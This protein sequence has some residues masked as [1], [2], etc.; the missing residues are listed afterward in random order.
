MICLLWYKA[1]GPHHLNNDLIYKAYRNHSLG[2]AQLEKDR[3]VL[4]LK[5]VIDQD[6][7]LFQIEL[8]FSCPIIGRFRF[9][10]LILVRAFTFLFSSW[11]S[12]LF[13]EVDTSES[14]TEG[15]SGSTLFSFTI[16]GH[17]FAFQ[18]PF[19]EL[20]RFFARRLVP[21]GFTGKPLLPIFL[22]LIFLLSKMSI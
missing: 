7:G 9:F 13:I 11:S 22:A 8:T 19:I 17:P 6:L 12:L 16:P 14:N 10:S 21:I 1:E 2:T 18:K 4:F 15:C 3:Q 20:K 5:Q